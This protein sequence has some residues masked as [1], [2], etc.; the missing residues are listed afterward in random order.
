MR[1]VKGQELEASGTQ[2]N[3]AGG[4]ATPSRGA[5]EVSVIRQRQAPGASNPLHRHDR[6]E[7]MVMLSGAVRVSTQ[8]EESVELA[9]GDALIVPAGTL[10]QIENHSGVEAEWLLSAPAGLRFTFADGREGS[11][12]WAR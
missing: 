11:P 6:E 5:E 10:H 1:V 4:I 8:E 3:F 12:A 7:V 2:G 9:A